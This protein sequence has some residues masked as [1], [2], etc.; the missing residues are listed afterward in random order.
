MGRWAWVS[1]TFY[2]LRRGKR[3]ESTDGLLKVLL[4]YMDN[5]VAR[6]PECPQGW[7]LLSRQLP[8]AEQVAFSGP[9]RCGNLKGH[10][11]E[12]RAT[13]QETPNSRTVTQ[14]LVE[15]E[16]SSLTMTFAPFVF[17]GM[18]SLVSGVWQEAL[19]AG[20]VLK[21]LLGSLLSQRLPALFCTFYAKELSLCCTILLALS[22]SLSILISP[23]ISF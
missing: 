5:S 4:K 23:A 20:R 8:Y 9:E 6:C 2:L 17:Q 14:P 7:G 21:E 1:S 10:V 11:S 19:E 16:L 13:A 15:G 3:R 22:S 12:H 18:L